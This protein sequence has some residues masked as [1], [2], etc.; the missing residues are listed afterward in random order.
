[1]CNSLKKTFF[2][3]LNDCYFKVYDFLRNVNKLAYKL[4]VEKLEI[5]ILNYLKKKVR[6][7]EF[8]T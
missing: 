5:T 7:L 3:C 6:G 8:Q 4:V 1:M 2:Y